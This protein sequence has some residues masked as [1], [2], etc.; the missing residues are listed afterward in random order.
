[1]R[2]IPEFL[3]EGVGREKKAQTLFFGAQDFCH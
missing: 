2:E 1:M 3:Y